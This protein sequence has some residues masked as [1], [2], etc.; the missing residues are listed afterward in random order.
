[1]KKFLALIMVLV[2]VCTMAVM[3]ACSGASNSDEVGKTHVQPLKANPQGAIEEI[4]AGCSI[5]NL[6]RATDTEA[7]EEIGLSLEDV[8]THYIM[9]SKGNYGVKDTYIVS[10]IPGHEAQ[11]KAQLEARQDA[12]IRQ[13]EHYDIYESYSISL[14]AVIYEQGEYI[15]MLMHD[16]ND[17]VRDVI[18]RYIPSK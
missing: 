2:A 4:Y 14:G 5:K 3:T 18:D 7:V 9:Y 8:R 11:V 13:Y 17:A 6:G 16:D 15:I 10:P 1:M 12:M